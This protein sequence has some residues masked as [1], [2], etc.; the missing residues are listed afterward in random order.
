[1]KNIYLYLDQ[2]VA[3]DTLIHTKKMFSKFLPNKQIIH[4][5][6]ENLIH[7]SWQEN[8][9][10]LVIPGGAD[11]SYAEKLNGRGNE[12]IKNFVRE[13]GK[14]LGICAGSYY[15]SSEIEFDKAGPLEVIGRRELG[16]FP[17]KT[18]GP[19]LS[20][21][22][23]TSNEGATAAK[24][25]F[26][27]QLMKMLSTRHIKLFHHGGGF[28]EDAA[29]YPG[30]EVLAHYVAENQSNPPAIIK[31]SFGKGMAVLSG[32]HFEIDPFMLNSEDP[33]LNDI[34]HQLQENDPAREEMLEYLFTWK[35]DGLLI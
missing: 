7:G 26:T 15:A 16:F 1:V 12:V 10:L 32:V 9:A 31:V 30:V 5:N 35:M 23:Y 3:L 13:G 18:I 6:A 28:F 33:H 24:I 17:G 19:A 21:Y 22:N 27:F 4:I 34:I 29:S 8:A 2:G 20:Y 14:Y 11:L 25:S